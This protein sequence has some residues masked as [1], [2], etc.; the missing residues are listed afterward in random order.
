MQKDKVI[1]QKAN[2][3]LEDNSISSLSH[4]NTD[5]EFE[6]IKAYPVNRTFNSLMA[7]MVVVICIGLGVIIGCLILLLN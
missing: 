4:F 3:N 1:Q 2:N 5:E 6:K 7:F